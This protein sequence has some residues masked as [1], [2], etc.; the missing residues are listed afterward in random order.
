MDNPPSPLQMHNTTDATATSIPPAESGQPAPLGTPSY[1]AVAP[2][3][4]LLVSI[5]GE[6]AAVKRPTPGPPQPREW[7][8]GTVQNFSAR[9]RSRMLQSLA[10]IDRRQVADGALFVTLTYPYDWPAT[11]AACKAHLE[12]FRKRVERQFPDAW[13]YWK[14]EFQKRG[15][16]HFHLLM[17]NVPTCNPDWFHTAWHE[18]VGSD[19]RYH[20]RYGADVKRC[21]SWKQAGSYCAKYC[22][23]IDETPASGN[24]GRFWGVATRRNRVQTVLEI[25][26]SDGE[27][28]AIR[29]QFRRLLGAGRGY[30][31]PGGPTS[32]VWVRLDWRQSIRLAGWAAD[33]Y[34]PLRG[35]MLSPPDAD[36]AGSGMRE[37]CTGESSIS[38]WVSG[39][40]TTT[41]RTGHNATLALFD[42]TDLQRRSAQRLWA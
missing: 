39:Q 33:E 10:A 27:F 30:H 41:D 2:S 40:R 42:S 17:F 6:Y 29:R 8:R 31:Q 18:V 26:I 12:S 21:N 3:A 34:H 38:G 15:A 23:K 32:G 22:A 16:E 36:D 4:R 7:K 24:P 1:T 25:E 35:R 14:L 13:F 9:S 19:D 37:P 20:W 28:Y 11:A 5:G